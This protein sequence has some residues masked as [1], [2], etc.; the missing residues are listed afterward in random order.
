MAWDRVRGHD[1]AR[2][3]L[4]AAFAA[5]RLAHGYLFVGPAGIGKHTF[6]IEFARALLC[7]SPPASLVACGRC[8]GCVQVGAATHPDLFTV[9]TPDDKHELLVDV[10][11]G[12]CVSLGR[13]ANRGGRKVGLVETADDLNEESANCF[14]KTLEE[15]PSGTVLIL[16]GESADAQLSTIRSRCQ[17]IH[18]RPLSDSDMQAILVEHKIEP[19]RLPQL[20]KLASG[21]PGLALALA[22]PAVWAFRSSLVD[23]LT[24]AKPDGPRLASEMMGFVESAGKESV[25]QRERATVAV[26]LV[27]GTLRAALHASL[28]SG[29][30][31]VDVS[32]QTKVQSLGERLGP[33]RLAD[34]LDACH[35]AG[36]LIDR[37]V[38]LVLVTEQLV[39]RLT[40]SLRG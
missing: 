5:G 26:R 33:D 4:Q 21:R 24:S 23:R 32:E 7:E 28:G 22:D 8:S 13:K 37:R 30:Q 35:T 16:L 36:N 12:F 15:P 14:L 6:A 38:S 40:I 9:R 18:F 20:M 2:E 31:T 29:P 34:L 3:Q 1:A 10:M 19:D 27:V 17:S 25:I 11:R 39:D